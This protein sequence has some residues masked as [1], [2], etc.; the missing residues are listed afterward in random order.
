MK[1]R[2]E[3]REGLYFVCIPGDSNRYVVPTIWENGELRTFRNND[4]N[5][6]LCD[7]NVPHIQFDTKCEAINFGQMLMEEHYNHPHGRFY[8]CRWCVDKSAAHGKFFFKDTVCV[9]NQ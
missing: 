4:G 1:H 3:H 8:V 6:C 7:Q 5:G 9:C 2:C